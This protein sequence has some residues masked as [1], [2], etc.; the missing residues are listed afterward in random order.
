MLGV[1]SAIVL[2]QS[3]KK[4]SR[5]QLKKEDGQNEYEADAISNLDMLKALEIAGVR[6]FKFELGELIKNVEYA[7][8][9]MNIKMEK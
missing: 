3:H 1:I 7:F 6:I 4:D 9:R 5:T 2:S 8:W